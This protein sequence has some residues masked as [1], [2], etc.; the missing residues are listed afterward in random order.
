VRY[1]TLAALLFLAGLA[2]AQLK[3]TDQNYVPIVRVRTESSLF[4]TIVQKVT[5]E[6]A[7]CADA[8][9]DM[10]AEIRSTCPACYVESSE[11]SAKLSG[12]DRALAAGD[13]L[14]VHTI[15]ADG[16]RIAM[17]GPPSRAHSQCTKMAA[18][19]ASNGL[20]SATCISPKFG[21]GEI[22]KLGD[23]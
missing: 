20:T 18:V 11:C 3:G 23:G 9:A 4:V 6:R 10:A 2:L 21:D 1:A 16:V 17:L 22:T 7:A 14:P 12:I 13:A 8:I 5:L 15:S 19:M